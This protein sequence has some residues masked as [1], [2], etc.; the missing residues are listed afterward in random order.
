MTAS[1]PMG[2]AAAAPSPPP[3]ETLGFGAA[4]SSPCSECGQ[5]PCCTYLPLHSFKVT[6]LVELD[7][8]LY[9]LNFAN[10][11]LGLSASGD[12]SVYHTLPCH[13]LDTEAFT[14]T[15]HDGPAQPQICVHYNAYRCWYKRVLSDGETEDFL[16]IDR[17][18]MAFILEHLR[19]DAGRSLVEVP[20][21]SL[22]QKTF[23]GTPAGE[24]GPRLFPAA[25]PMLQRWKELA[26]GAQPAPELPPPLTYEQARD[27]CGGCPA[28]CCERL[29]FPHGMPSTWSNLDFLQFTLGF[30]GVE[31]AITDQ[32]WSV[33]VRTRCQH[34]NDGRCALYGRPERPLICKYHA[35]QTCS[36]RAHFGQPRPGHLL[37]VTASELPLIMEGFGFDPQG[38]ITVFP[39]TEQMRNHLEARWREGVAA[40]ARAAQPTDSADPSA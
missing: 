25:D 7:H 22:M 13:L 12:W 3:A 33:V 34:L 40:S 10:I 35:A 18:R 15:V 24:P 9:L 5:S 29:I 2:P 21:W 36:Y 39:T 26:T 27:A 11:E 6:N 14:C 23:A 1:S 37:R 4:L 38:L 32:A 19:F 28:Y 20:D 16:R 17:G 31:L 8:A 30:P